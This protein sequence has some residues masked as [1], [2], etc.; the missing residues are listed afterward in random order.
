MTSHRT[1]PDTSSLNDVADPHP[2]TEEHYDRQRRPGGANPPR[3]DIGPNP[4]RHDGHPKP[5]PE[6]AESSA[7]R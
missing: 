6:N 1:G 3:G 4:A 7:P 2:S 5:K